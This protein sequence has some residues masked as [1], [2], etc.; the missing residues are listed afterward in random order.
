MIPNHKKWLEGA[1]T[2]LQVVV[3]KLC[4][5]MFRINLYAKKCINYHLLD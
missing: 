5:L 3:V 4:N 1:S 2:T